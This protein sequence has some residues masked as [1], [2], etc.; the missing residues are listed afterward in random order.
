V[1]VWSDVEGIC[2]PS[3]GDGTGIAS[4]PYDLMITIDI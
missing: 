4:S 1:E 2:T 3:A